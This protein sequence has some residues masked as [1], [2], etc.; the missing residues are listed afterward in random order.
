M[1]DRLSLPDL[2]AGVV[3]DY[4]T[5]RDTQKPE[6]ILIKEAAGDVLLLAYQAR[7]WA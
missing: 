3:G 2:V 5:K 6:D 4:L 7:Y 1:N